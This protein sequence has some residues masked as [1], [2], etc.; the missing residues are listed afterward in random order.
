[1][2]FE[3]RAVRA[4]E[5][6]PARLMFDNMPNHF[7]GHFR[8]PCRSFPADTTEQP[9]MRNVGCPQPIVDRL[10]HPRGHRYRPNVPAL[11]IKSTMAQ[12]SSRR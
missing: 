8:A 10:F 7:L 3:D 5:L 4:L 1:M 12:W 2:T 9:S 6:Q 11:P